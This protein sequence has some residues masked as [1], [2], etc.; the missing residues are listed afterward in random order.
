MEIRNF[1]KQA[2]IGV[3][4][5]VGSMIV[6]GVGFFILA[7]DIQTQVQAV[8]AGRDTVANQ[9]VLINSY[10]NLKENAPAAATYQ[11]AMDKLLATQDDLIGFPSQID[12]VA[13]NDN[14]DL[15]FSFEGDPVSAGSSTVG[16]VGFKLN[17]IG[18]LDGI[19]AFLKDVELSAPISF[20]KIDSFDLTQDGSNYSLDAEGR[21]FFR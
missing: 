20:S 9:S 12:G 3:G 5:V 4:I 13:R 15:T 18:S 17:A 2:W 21:V 6:F 16:Y 1:K 19:T 11:A 14:V 10:S 7:G 8:T